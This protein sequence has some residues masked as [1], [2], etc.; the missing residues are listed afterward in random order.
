[1]PDRTATTQKTEPVRV[2]CPKC[3]TL[4]PTNHRNFPLCS[5][6]HCSEY[7]TKCRYC[8]WYDPETVE[9]TNRE[10]ASLMGDI[11]GRVVIRDIDAYIDCPQ[12]R[13]TIMFSAAVQAQKLLASLTRA[14]VFLLVV[15][16][17]AYAGYALHQKLEK[18]DTSAGISLVTDPPREEE[19]EVETEFTIR[20]AVRNLRPKD[21]GPI[22]LRLSEGFF[23]WFELR[24]IYPD[25]RDMFVRGAGRYF[26]FDSIP[27]NSEMLVTMRFKPTQAG[28][29][30]FKVAIFSAENVVYTEN[31]I[32]VHV[33]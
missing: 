26:V 11:T 29:Y 28:S 31:K 7:L 19:V 12:H 24:D 23:E 16:S 21:T 22:Q 4:T 10:I 13:S 18:K 30:P 25:N 27:G 3:R 33:I 15:L 9:C 1:M 17:L 6:R 14:L 5:N 2:R 32:W 8:S 20:F